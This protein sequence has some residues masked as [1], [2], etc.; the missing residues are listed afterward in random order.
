MLM[1]MSRRDKMKKRFWESM[2]FWGAVGIGTTLMLEQL[3][4]GWPVLI[5]I[6]QGLSAFL[7]VFGIRRA[8]K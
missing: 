1:A 4:V 2:T 7:G 6:A 3:G 8:L 5:P